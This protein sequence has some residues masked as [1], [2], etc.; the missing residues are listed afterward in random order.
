MSEIE[1]NMN[2]A[3]QGAASHLDEVLLL[4]KS[5]HSSDLIAELHGL[6]TQLVADF[7]KDLIKL[8]DQGRV[9]GS[10]TGPSE[11]QKFTKLV[12]ETWTR[13]A[14]KDLGKWKDSALAQWTRGTMEFWRTKKMQLMESLHKDEVASSCSIGPYAFIFSFP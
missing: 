6:K 3:I 13:T 4:E 8:A 14:I 11:I 2:E 7:E 1:S 10:K 12:Q 9:P 5:S